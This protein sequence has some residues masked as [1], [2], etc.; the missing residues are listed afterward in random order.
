MM[1][2]NRHLSKT[3][4]KLGQL[5]NY[6]YSWDYYLETFLQLWHFKIWKYP[7]EFIYCFLR[8]NLNI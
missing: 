5:C 1:F 6:I 7:T 2:I 8:H 4:K 3:R